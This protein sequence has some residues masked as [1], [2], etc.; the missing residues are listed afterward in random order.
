MAK[1]SNRTAYRALAINPFRVMDVLKR[2]REL[3]A[4]G[5]DIVHM[6]VGEPDFTTAE[7]IV[8]AGKNALDSGFTQYANAAGLPALREAISSY[9]SERYGVDISPCRIFITPGASGG[10]NLLANLLIN[11]Q[12]GVLLADPS[13]PCNRN[14]IRLVGG[15]PQL[16]PV[17]AATHFQPD[18]ASLER[19]SDSSTRGLWLAS[20]SNPT[21][22]IIDRANLQLLSD[23]ASQRGF[24]LLIDEI[25]HGLHYVEDLPSLLEINQEAF[26][27]NSF[28]KYFGM[29]G[30]RIGWIVVPEHYAERVDIL[31]QNMFISASTIAQHAALRA[32]APE[33][34]EILEQRR[35]AFLTRRDFLG[36]ALKDLKFSVPVNTAG[37]F[38]IYAGIERFSDDSEEFCR[39]LLER[40]GVALTPGTDFG[41]NNANSFVRIAFTTRME[42]LQQG[43]ERMQKALS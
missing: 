18:V 28:S 17:S 24:H 9:Y 1:N 25:Y 21:G 30:W 22:T 16:V 41:E 5:K 11:P 3:E 2:A 6:E 15:V 13:Y 33:T 14:F 31:A 29:T 12:D 10:L 43:I 4:L 20:P 32:F 19:V 34:I 7:P 40:F 42:K 36:Q 8:A 35:N 39:D 23:W 37:A 27:V 38:Y 26:I